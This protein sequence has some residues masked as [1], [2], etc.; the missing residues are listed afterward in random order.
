[1]R[2]SEGLGIKVI[3]L[4]ML[5][6]VLSSSLAF[7]KTKAGV[8]ITN[9][10]EIS[11][12]DTEDGLVKH[13]F[14]NVS[15]VVV[16]QQFS[17]LLE[18]D[19]IR[20]SAAGKTVTLP[21]RLTNTGNVASSYELR[22]RDNTDD[23]GSLGSLRLFKDNNGNGAADPGEV[24]WPAVACLP[25]E[26]G[27]SCY[28]IPRLEP[29]AV[30][31]FVATGITPNNGQ[32]GNTYGLNVRVFPTQYDQIVQGVDKVDT[33]KGRVES[34]QFSAAI[35]ENALPEDWVNDDLVDLITGAVLTIN[36]S[37]TPICGVPVKAEQP[38][39]YYIN[40]SNIGSAAPQTRE[41][42]IDGESI[43]G[44]MLED[45]LPPNVSLDKA[46][47]PVNA[48][49]QSITTVQLKAEEDTNR[50][51]RFST[52]DG[53]DVISKIGLYIPATQIEPNESGQLQFDVN[54]N[55]NVTVST[56]YNQA[57]FDL[58]EGGV[59]EFSS[60]RVCATIEPGNTRSDQGGQPDVTNIA[61]IRFLTPTLDIKRDITQS[62]NEPDFYSDS[63]F[64]DASIYRLDSD[65]YDVIRDGVYIELSSSGFN[66]DIDTAELI[67]VTV[68]SGTG[69]KLQVSLLETGPNTGIFRSLHPI[70]LSASE[71]GNNRLCPGGATTP[72]FSAADSGCVLNGAADS[73]LT[74]TADDPGVGRI[75]EDAALIDPLGVV[76]DSAYG[77]PVGGATVWIRNADGSIATDPLTDAPYEAQVTGDDG[78]YQF[79]YLVPGQYYLDVNPPAQYSFPSV[80]AGGN[81]IQYTVNEYSYGKDGYEQVLNSGVFDLA[82]LLVVDIPLDPEMNTDLSVYK[83][84]SLAEVS[85]GG[86]IAYTVKIKNHSGNTL[87]NIKVRDSLPR[88]FNYVDGTAELNGVKIDD[89]AGA[90]RPNLVFSNLPFVSGEADGVL[91][92]IEHTLTYRVRTT[93]GA[94]SSDGINVVQADGRTE[95]SFPIESNESRAKVLIQRDGVLA[96]NGIVF[97][98][99][100]VDADCNN[101][102]NGGE[103][104]I[105]GVKL[106]ME[107]GT[108]V[109]TDANGQYSLYGIE[110]GN[111]VI[112][113][114]PFTLPKGIQF[115]PTDNR[116]MADPGSRLVDLTSGEFHRADFAAVCPKENKQEIHAE[117]MARNAGQTDWMLQNAQKYDPDKV[118]ANDDLRQKSDSTGDISSGVVGESQLTQQSAGR[119]N[120]KPTVTTGYSVQLSQFNT[121]EAAEKALEQLPK[122]TAKES[123]VYRMGDFFT[124]RF[125][126]ELDKKAMTARQRQQ[127]FVDSEIVAT[128]YERLSDEVAD[129]LETPRGLETMP[130]AKDVVKTLTKAQAKAG[131]WLWPK[132]NVSLDG[133]FMVSVRKG[134]TPTLMVNGKPVPQSQLGEQIENIRESAQVVAW[135]GVQLQPG[136]NKLE[137]VAKDMFGNTRVLA[138]GEFTRPT[139]AAKLYI[140]SDSD[141]LPADGGRSYLP[142]TIKLLDGNGY[143][144]RGVNFVTIEASDGTWVERDVQDQSQGRQVRVVNGLRTVNLR[145]SERSGK[146]RVRISDGSMRDEME[147]TQIAP[148]RPLIAVGVV[149]VG[150]HIFKRGESSPDLLNENELNARAAFFLKGRVGEDMHLTMS[151]DTDKESD[152][153]L[154]RDID[155]NK[156]YPIHGD[157]SQ[158]GYEAQSRSPVYAKLEKDNDSIMWGDF[159]TDGSTFNEDVTRV[160]RSLTGANLITK[161]GPNEWQ[162]FVSE[163]DENNIVE[164][165]RGRGVA[166]N[167]QLTNA[168]I[169]TN[170]D[171]LEIITVSRDNPGVVVSTKQLSRFGDYTLD[172]VTGEL[173]FNEVVPTVDDELNPVY[174][175]A[176]YDV[177]SDGENYTIAGARVTHEVKPGFKVGLSYTVDQNESDG[178]EIYGATLQYKDDDGLSAQ[179]SIAQLSPRESGSESGIGGRLHL[180]KDWNDKS[181]TSITLGRATSGFDHLGAGISAGREELRIKH[182][183]AIYEGVKAQVEAIH[184]KDLETGAKEQSVG[185]TADVKVE[186]WTLKGGFRHIEQDNELES[187]SFQTFIVGAK[188]AL[189]ILGRTGSLEAEY[190]QAIGGSDRQRIALTADMQVHE[191]VKL[192]ARGERINSLSGISGLS[193]TSDT[194]DTIAIG[195]KSNILPSTE[196]FSEYRVR[197]GIDGRDMETA[198]G[199][200]GTYELTKGLSFSPH[201]ELVNNIEGGDSDSISTSVA[202]KDTRSP[203]QVSSIRFETRHDDTRDY[204]GV[205]ADYA[206]RLDQD[207]SVLLKNTLRFDAPDDDE[208]FVQNTLTLGLAY[209]PRRENKHHGLFFYQNKETRG[210][211]NG[212]C[213]THILST[214]QNYEFNQDVLISARAGAKHED[215]EGN[216]SNAALLDGRITWDI[217]RRFDVDVRGGV[218]GTDGFNEKN[219][220]FGAGVNY[221]VKENLR[222]GIGYNLNG[223]NDDDLDPENY[224]DKGFYM[225]LQYKF[226]EKSLN[227][228]TG[229]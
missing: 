177:E 23:S 39:R 194:Q 205:Q 211:D 15:T 80:V 60:N 69:D 85:I 197:G 213:S 179:G 46:T 77:N 125:G 99:V 220:S 62:G 102:Q 54:I 9:Q 163:L 68:S 196:L 193:S 11:W 63:D 129:Q 37:S 7:A 57:H 142:I 206:R 6:L 52:W 166:L 93:A 158:R 159:I 214:H 136:N 22:I 221:L 115:K 164:R 167:Y 44:V 154:F 87:Y 5:Y 76:F 18:S 190:E 67:V 86:S 143:L 30:V 117:I 180:S 114:D 126:F 107:D 141:Q 88:G 152:A 82:S 228:L 47:I 161:G 34:V 33:T 210:D 89:P 123:F 208:D 58:D 103:W 32:D 78:K 212:D 95:T 19:N 169:V 66:E 31:E 28:E 173:S 181:T 106:Y 137:V 108:W 187:E 29:G 73:N 50:W 209:R 71:V 131:A 109:I 195:V 222:L 150:G 182:E 198:S 14:S 91:D 188:H 121:E 138:K 90:P 127:K 8:T 79:P 147:L 101:V 151:V 199:V 81:F 42:S 165:I 26:E 160:Q 111:H 207:W 43:T 45:V 146:I 97:G 124:V 215:C 176:T 35:N 40:F 140:E 94:V 132:D 110:P 74:V 192:Y 20:H 49:N 64:E 113:M 204:Y 61:K 153:T 2:K 200:R 156:S 184:S 38:I 83:T 189:D 24:E 223:F 174:I 56:I 145:S 225:G 172:D 144:A 51:I 122:V 170:S 171:T 13:A 98:K 27:V 16:A 55:P 216:D 1:M 201:L 178:F 202:F 105:A 53:V 118:Q 41:F 100:Y 219:Y 155:P 162:F 48:P 25:S 186:D 139:S 10:A 191:K 128:I 21:H 12:F 133:R 227:W 217:N 72:Q 112:K 130:L 17:L 92:S 183:Q 65:S 226:D 119:N 70:R 224:N 134:L 185:L 218:L 104:P 96:D 120:T 116:Q 229:E 203:N 4:I 148:L 36:K 157:S 75:L 175:Q 149:E 84:A 135:Y 3:S 59:A 168:P